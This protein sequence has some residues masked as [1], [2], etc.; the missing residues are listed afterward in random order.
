[1]ETKI[2]NA[3]GEQIAIIDG[4]IMNFGTT[5]IDIEQLAAIAEADNFK[6]MG[7]ALQDY[8][9]RTSQLMAAVINSEDIT[10]KCIAPWPQDMHSLHG[11][12]ERLTKLEVLNA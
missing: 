9:L 7:K 2:L 10:E 5:K 1:M 4:Q 6:Q 8:F 12:A 11:L 3:A